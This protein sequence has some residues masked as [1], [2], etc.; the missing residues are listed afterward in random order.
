MIS[1]RAL[2]I[3][4]IGVPVGFII[5]RTLWPHLSL[6][7]AQLKL[8]YNTFSFRWLCLRQFVAAGYPDIGDL[9]QQI[10]YWKGR[11]DDAVNHQI[12]R[13][14]AGQ[15]DFVRKVTDTQPK[16][17]VQINGHLTAWSVADWSKWQQGYVLVI[18]KHAFVD[19]KRANDKMHLA[20]QA[21]RRIKDDNDVPHRQKDKACQVLNYIW[22]GPNELMPNDV[23]T[24][25]VYDMPFSIVKAL[26][27]K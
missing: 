3:F 16:I 21:K 18:T 5:L 19:E 24:D 2:I 8:A 12:H 7:H 4:A 14:T 15:L 1:D 6:K 23:W 20:R 25:Y 9:K 10:E 11:Y 27:V 26:K 22:K 17:K 13:G